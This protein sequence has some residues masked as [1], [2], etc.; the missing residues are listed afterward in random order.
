NIPVITFFS[1]K[2]AVVVDVIFAVSIVVLLLSLFL[3]KNSLLQDITLF[4]TVFT[5]EIHLLFNS[6]NYKYIN[7]KIHKGV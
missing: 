3:F 4:I 6:E 2:V 7:N 1:N 5:F